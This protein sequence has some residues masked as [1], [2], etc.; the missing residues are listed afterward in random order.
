M[1]APS[2]VVKVR[3]WRG[4]AFVDSERDMRW[5][6]AERSDSIAQPG[7]LLV[8]AT[9][10][11]R[12]AAEAGMRERRVSPSYAALR[13]LADT[14]YK[15]LGTED[16][17]AVAEWI[18]EARS[19]ARALPPAAPREGGTLEREALA[20]IIAGNND[21]DWGAHNLTEITDEEHESGDGALCP[22]C[23]RVADAI[24]AAGF[25]R[26]PAAG[27]GAQRK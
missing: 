8:F 4:D 14:C 5:I 23:L 18:T 13:R 12:D 2:E 3:A 25:R 19:L 16:A 22:A 11:E 10:A 26:A 20:K 9:E 24:L 6:G 27:T 17:D 15:Y 1:T 21:L 7:L